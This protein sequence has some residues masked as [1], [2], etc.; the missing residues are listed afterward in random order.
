MFYSLKNKKMKKLAFLFAAVTAVT[1][2]A[3]GNKAAEQ[4]QDAEAQ[5]PETEVCCQKDSCEKACCQDS[6]QDE[7]PAEEAPAAE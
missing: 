2:A 3:C 5:E 6:C 7:S 4:T 1:F